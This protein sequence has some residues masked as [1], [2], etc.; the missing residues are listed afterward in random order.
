MRNRSAVSAKR[1][2]IS[3]LRSPAAR[4]A[5][6]F[7]SESSFIDT[8]SSEIHLRAILTILQL[9]GATNTEEWSVAGTEA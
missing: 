2:S 3:A 6:L 4:V 8:A 9:K 5:S 7:I 1:N